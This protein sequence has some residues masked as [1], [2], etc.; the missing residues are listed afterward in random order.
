MTFQDFHD[1]YEPWQKQVT[2]IIFLPSGEKNPLLLFT[3]CTTP[4]TL[5]SDRKVVV[6]AM[7][8]WYQIL[9]VEKDPSKGYNHSNKT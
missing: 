8:I 5:T 4:M 2:N 9:P 6:S 1:L 3:I 7:I